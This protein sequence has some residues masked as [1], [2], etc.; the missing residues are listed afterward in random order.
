[1]RPLLSIVLISWN[2]KPM[3]ERCLLSLSKLYARPDVE[4]IW[5]DNGSTDGAS[6]LVTNLWP[7]VHAVKLDHNYGVAYAR[8]RGIELSRGKYVL[9]LD[10]DTEATPEAIDRL[11]EYMEA[12]PDVGVSAC[13]LR[14]GQGRLQA[15]FKSY[16]G[17]GVKV[18][19]VVSS[20]LKKDNGEVRLP[21]SV[22]EPEYVIG[23]CQMIRHEVIDK[24]G[25][26]DEKIFYG[27]EDADFC[28]RVR[29]AG[30]RVCYL[31]DVSIMHHWRRITNRN[32]L[33]RISRLHI[34]ALIH[35]YRTHRRLW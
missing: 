31:P 17:L 32:P 12:N 21:D 13:A 20:W 7:R 4:V 3:L 10:D 27:P 34:R 23:A 15:S 14:D 25:L 24:V 30:Y 28:I 22:I 29:R 16:P 2:S 18:R 8:N 1:M 35:F 9:L 19:N 6:H 5:I 33:S 11:I 26:L